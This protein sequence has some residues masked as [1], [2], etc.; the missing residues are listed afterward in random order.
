[1]RKLFISI[2]VVCM[3]ITMNAQTAK[4][5]IAQNVYLSASNYLAYPG[6]TGKLTPTPVG[7][8][9][10]YISHYGRHGSRYLIGKGD[11]D[12]P[13]KTMKEAD[14]KGILTEK[15]K[16]VL[17]GL[18]MMQNESRDRL[19]ELTLLG[20]Q[21]HHDIAKRMYERFPEVFADSAE[22]DARSTVVIRCILSMENEL[23]Q[24]ASMNPK[25]KISHDASLHDMWYMN[26]D[27]HKLGKKKMTGTAKEA[28]DAFCKKHIHPDRVMGELFNDTAYINNNIDKKDLYYKLFQLASNLQSSEL[29]H[30]ISLY[31]LFNS[32]EIYESWQQENVWWYINYAACP[33]NG[34]DQPFTQ[35][36][37]LKNILDYADSAM[38]KEHPGATLRFGHEVVV[39]PLACLL[40]LN[41]CGEKI[42]NMEQ[43]D[44][45]EW[46]NYKI[47]PMGSNIQFIFY[48]KNFND[49]D[50]LV[51]VLLNENEATLPIKSN[52]APYYHWKDV[53]TYYRNKLAGYQE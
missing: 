23:Q 42:D 35:R 5:E 17:K 7:E 1:M 50:V 15:G 6:P 4:K 22:I 21:Q 14:K 3:A 41:N 53:E 48:R 28:Y 51:K 20:A 16:E 47:F 18:I 25:L 26:F 31:D 8:K 52:I 29:R 38:V 39:L 10:F 37:L 24:L 30:T 36:N 40:E 11:Y 19:G 43:L 49:K 33:L 46:K 34:G 32:D 12:S 44:K 27:D 9:P 45:K 2:I 13:I